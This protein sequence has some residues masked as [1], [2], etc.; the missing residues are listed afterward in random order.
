MHLHIAGGVLTLAALVW[1]L[2]KGKAEQLGAAAGSAAVGAVIGVVSG[3]GGAVVDAANNH[4]I[5][6]LQPVGAWLGG[7][8]YDMTHW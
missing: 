6:P 7:T 3:A 5:N 4:D 8:I 2:Q 1:L